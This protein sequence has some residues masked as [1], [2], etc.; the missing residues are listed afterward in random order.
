MD[1]VHKGDWLKYDLSIQE[2]GR[3]MGKERRKEEKGRSADEGCQTHWW[4]GPEL[5]K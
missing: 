4:M 2:L 1:F 3:E 5:E